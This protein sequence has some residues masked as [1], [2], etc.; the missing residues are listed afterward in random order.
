MARLICLMVATALLLGG[1]ARISESRFNPLNIFRSE[2][3]RAVIDPADIRPLVP[4]DR[5]VQTVEARPL[6]SQ[7][8]ELEV[9]PTIGGVIVRASGTASASGAFSAQLTTRA[10]SSDVI[11]LDFRAFQGTGPGGGRVTAARFFS[12]EELGSA[13][14]ISVRSA[15]NSL[16]RRR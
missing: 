3:E 13:R 4:P 10:V 5:V 11:E 14:T 15:T 1:C 12:D 2:E 6:V 9:T 7:L 16:S 8:A